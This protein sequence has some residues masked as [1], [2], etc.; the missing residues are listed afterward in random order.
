MTSKQKKT[1]RA[2]P[3]VFCC[4]RLSKFAGRYNRDLT[5]YEYDKCKKDTIALGEDKCVQ[6]ALDFCSKVKR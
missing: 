4:Y 3:H 5:P 1:N 6:K 2:R